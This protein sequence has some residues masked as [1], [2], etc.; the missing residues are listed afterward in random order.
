MISRSSWR[1]S[2]RRALVGV[3]SLAA[4]VLA[5]GVGGHQTAG[6]TPLASA[7]SLFP[8]SDQFLY[9]RS[10]GAYLQCR[11]L[12]R[13]MTCKMGPERSREVWLSEARPGLLVER[14]SR[15]RKAVA[16]QQ[17]AIYLGNRK[18]THA[19]IAS[20]A[21][22]G[23][24]LLAELQAGRVSGQGNGGA[25]Y[26]YVQLTDALRE[27]AMPVAVRRAILEALPLVPGVTQLGPRSDR[28]GRRGL[29]FARR[30]AGTRE[31]VIVDPESLV[32]LEE[33]TIMLDPS[34]APGSGKR[35]GER[36]GGAVYVK[37][38]V[39]NRAGQRP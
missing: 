29:G 23:A 19:E 18:F 25:S 10:K 5:V 27:T 14:P 11:Q 28:L 1:V 33:R 26:P 22:S 15:F 12:K 16:L 20:Y 31:E 21:P 34:V 39:V 9:V 7:P 3:G 32:M 37:R 6:A 2:Y 36:I 24:A 13:S 30:V 4:F 17:H 8:A 38:A 35:V